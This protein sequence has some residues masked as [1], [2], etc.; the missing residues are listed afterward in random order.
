[1]CVLGQLG[2]GDPGV[3]ETAGLGG[4]VDIDNIRKRERLHAK[5]VVGLRLVVLSVAND[6]D[7]VGAGTVL[8][9]SL[10]LQVGRSL[11]RGAEHRHPRICNGLDRASGDVEVDCIE[12]LQEIV[13]AVGLGLLHGVVVPGDL[14]DLR[15]ACV[16]SNLGQ[17]TGNLDQRASLAPLKRSRVDW[18]V[19]GLLARLP[20]GDDFAVDGLEILCVKH[21]VARTD[22]FLLMEWPFLFLYHAVR[23]LLSAAAMA[24]GERC[25]SCDGSFCK[26]I[27]GGPP[28]SFARRGDA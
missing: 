24:I 6:L 15:D 28:S 7:K 3:R 19:R 2:L 27:S 13:E 10:M 9:V 25:G 5:E 8:G 12:L 21:A 1:M 17:F 4:A 26:G 22:Q 20:E 23:R 18:N 11:D 14:R 16:A